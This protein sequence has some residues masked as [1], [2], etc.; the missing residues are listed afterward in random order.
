MSSQRL[1]SDQIFNGKV[2]S[3]ERDRV[4][5]ANG[6]E[7]TLDIVRHPKSVVLVPRGP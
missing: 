6:R 2:F 4:R 7:V 1:S 5:L 3:I